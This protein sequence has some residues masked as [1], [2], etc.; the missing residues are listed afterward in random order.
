MTEYIKS[1]RTLRLTAEL[2]DDFMLAIILIIFTNID[3]ADW[4]WMITF[5]SGIPFL[6]LTIPS[7]GGATLVFYFFTKDLMFKNASLGKRIMGLIILDEKWEVP[8][9]KQ[10]FKRGVTMTVMG[11]VIYSKTYMTE[12]DF[13]GW[14]L[15]KSH[16]RVLS[17]YTFEEL[18]NKA[19]EMS[20]SFEDN[21]DVLYYKLLENRTE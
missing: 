13:E 12:G 20:G 7:I 4:F 16:T 19:S 2:I 18:C 21:M 6:S 9:A 14:E 15:S 8:N 5:D 3:L 17:K 11:M 10:I 1:T